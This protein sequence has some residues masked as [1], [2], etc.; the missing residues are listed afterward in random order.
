MSLERGARSVGRADDV[1]L[2][3]LLWRTWHEAGLRL[4]PDRWSA[5]SG[6]GDWTVRELYAHVVRGVTT[7]S[8]LVPVDSEPELPDAAAYFLALRSLGD[9][10]AAQVAA[11]ARDWAAER[12]LDTLV[13]DFGEPAVATLAAVRATG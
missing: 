7:T 2:L 5:P 13:A 4:T 6:L 10:G 11:S 12:D 8:R 9:E 1:D 3:D